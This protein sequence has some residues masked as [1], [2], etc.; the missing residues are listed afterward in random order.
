MTSPRCTLSIFAA[1]TDMPFLGYTIPHLVRMCRYNFV[2]KVLVVD[3]APLSGDKLSR[4][5]IGTLEELRAL[6]AKFVADGIIDR[7]IDINYDPTYQKKVYK[8]HLGTPWMRPTHNY[9]GY[10]ILGSIFKIE[11]APSDYVLHFDS[12]MLLYSEPGFSWIDEAIALTEAN[13][14]A[15]SFRPL[16]GPPRQAKDGQALS[17]PVDW[18]LDP[19]G[20]FYKFKF[21]GSRCYLV[22]RKRFDEIL[23]MPIIW[24]EKSFRNKWVHR[25]PDAIKVPLCYAAKRGKLQSWEIMVTEAIKDTP[26]YR[27][28][29]ASPKAWTVHPPKHGPEFVAAL[30]KLIEKIES[31]WYPDA[32]AG[33][34]DL[35]LEEWL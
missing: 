26:Y 20:N 34:Y 12:D 28:T 19:S 14:H 13:P 30:P 31:G 1:R 22:S 5:G 32:Q 2:E 10:P 27:G 4:P 7:V 3:T 9:K 16:T 17:Q 15:M 33:N 6:C 35:I 18:E 11:E 8:K 25:L 21:F 23:P 29:M 24:Y